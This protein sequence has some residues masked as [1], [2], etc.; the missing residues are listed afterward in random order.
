M[1]GRRNG[2]PGRTGIAIA[3]VGLGILLVGVFIGAE[4]TGLNYLGFGLVLAG[5][6]TT[7]FGVLREVSDRT[8]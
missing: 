2:E 7:L 6:L 5:A 3:A 4:L 8:R 1:M